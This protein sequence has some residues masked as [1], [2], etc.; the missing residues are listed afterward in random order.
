MAKEQAGQSPQ[1]LAEKLRENVNNLNGFG[2]YD[3]ISTTVEGAQNLD[4]SK[5]AL[6]NIFLSENTYKEERKNLKGRLESWVALL[7]TADDLTEMVSTAAEQT[8][9]VKKL[10]AQNVKKALDATNELEQSYRTV[11]LFFKNTGS[12]KVKNVSILNAELD[13]ITD[14]DNTVFIDH[15]HN[16]IKD[17]FDRLDLSRNY[18]L[19]VLPGYL[20]SNAVLEKWA[21]IAHENKV[22]MVTD[23]RDLEAP[24][25]VMALFESAKHA[26]SDAYRSNVLMTCNWL[27]GREKEA[28]LGEE[29]H[30]FVPPSA[31]LAGQLHGGKISQPSAG[32]KYGGLSEVSGVRFDLRHMEIS[33]IEKLGLIP[34]V[35]EFGKVMAF[36]SKTLFNGDNIGL[37]TYSVVRVFDWIAK[38]LC[39]YLNKM[40]FQNFNTKTKR[41]IEKQIIQFFEANKGSDKLI[42]KFKI[43]KFEQDP[44]QKDRILLDIHVKPFFPAKN[45]VIKL[46]GT[47]GDDPD[48]PDWNSEYEED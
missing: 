6:K 47:K 3:I 33:D 48:S 12:T 37:Q 39:D 46:D 8:D 2:G 10:L 34:M 19:M 28:E 30:L 16:E 5:K 38:S 43:L 13:Q 14:L 21:K 29:E 27:V 31:A 22:M 18:S 23:F 17:N 11:A 25:D 4:P 9:K 26:G 42:E 45:F 44:N 15:I 20:K 24:D 41:V 36:S 1:Q 7:E 32:Y 40:T 35:S